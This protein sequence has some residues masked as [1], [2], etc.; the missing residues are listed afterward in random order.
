MQRH[1]LLIEDERSI[2]DTVLYALKSEGFDASWAQTGAAGLELF[3]K[4][5][6]A[7]VVLDIGLPDVS[8]LDL[9]RRLRERSTV[10][11]IFLTARAEEVDRIVGLEL[12]ADDY[13]AKPFSPRELTARIRAVLRRLEAPGAAAGTG[14]FRHDAARH[15]IEYHGVA[16]ELSRYEYRLLKTLL[17][18]PGRVY[19]REQLMEKAWEHPEHS[20]DRT[21]D[22]HIKTLRAK[23]RAVKRDVDPIRTLR[24]VGYSL[25]LSA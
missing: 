5:R 12:G 22:T 1:I 10:P 18:H 21:V 14:P 3:E 16:L 19:S 23:L 4:L 6:P 8:G 2:A 15:R 9:C 17:E 20:L 25:E 13:L 11:V 24:G 7:L